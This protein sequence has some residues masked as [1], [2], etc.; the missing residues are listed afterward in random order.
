MSTPT[1]TRFHTIAVEGRGLYAG[2][3][4]HIIQ[5][6]GLIATIERIEHDGREHIIHWVQLDNAIDAEPKT[7]IIHLPDG[8]TVDCIRAADWAAHQDSEATR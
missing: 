3:R 1:T 8:A 2:Y 5:T 4:S 7:G 6:D